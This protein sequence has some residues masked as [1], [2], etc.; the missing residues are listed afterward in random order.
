LVGTVAELVGT[1]AESVTSFVPSVVSL[2]ELAT[3][4]AVP[5][6]SLAE[7]VTSAA[8]MVTSV[9][10]L[11]TSLAES[12]PVEAVGVPCGW[13]VM[14]FE[15]RCFGGLQKRCQEVFPRIKWVT[16]PIQVQI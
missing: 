5:A 8:G 11:A 14:G 2:A 10:G 7:S 1:I 16:G 13:R 6:T 12:N 15:A 4:I 9:T 3:S